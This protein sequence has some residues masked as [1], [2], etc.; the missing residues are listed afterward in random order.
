M[1]VSLFPGRYTI[2]D[3][4]EDIVV[5][6]IGMRINKW[7]AMHKWLPVLMAMPPMIRELYMNKELGCLS[8][9]NFSRLRTTLLI[10]YWQSEKH[11]MAYAR[12]QKH[13]KAWAD[14]NKKVGN[15]DAVGIYHETYIVPKGNYESIYGNMP[16]FGL[17]KVMG[18]TPITATTKSAEHR[19]KKTP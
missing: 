5:F 4:N 6:V 17:G 10:Q 9:E 11:L 14:F 18:T 16:K 1:G 13:L 3:N 2:T 12:G 15:N 8:M 19:L 7:W